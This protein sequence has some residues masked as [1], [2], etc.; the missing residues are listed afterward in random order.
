AGFLVAAFVYP[1][2][3]RA[4]AETNSS[5]SAVVVERA[6]QLRRARQPTKVLC[7]IPERPWF[8]HPGEMQKM[9]W[10]HLSYRLPALVRNQKI[11]LMPGNGI[12]AVRSLRHGR[13]AVDLESG[14]DQFRQTVLSDDTSVASDHDSHVYR[15]LAN[16]GSSLSWWAT[17]PGWQDPLFDF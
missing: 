10:P 13:Y 15:R 7:A 9:R 6:K 14:G 17:H 4:C 8:G 3:L 16:F 2:I 5:P 1:L 11:E 12:S